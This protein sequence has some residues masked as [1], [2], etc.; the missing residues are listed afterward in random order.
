MDFFIILSSLSSESNH[1]V[2]SYELNII[3]LRAIE[4]TIAET[5]SIGADFIHSN[6]IIKPK[7]DF[8]VFEKKIIEIEASNEWNAVESFLVCVQYVNQ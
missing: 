8:N 3:F 2:K 4:I 5:Y 7:V 1:K 6:L